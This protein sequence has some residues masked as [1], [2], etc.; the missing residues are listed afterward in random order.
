MT[1]QA[2]NIHVA[3]GG[4]VILVGI[5]T[6]VMGL[7]ELGLVLMIMGFLWATVARVFASD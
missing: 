1:N 4:I 7:G 6:I 2:S 5:F 3:L